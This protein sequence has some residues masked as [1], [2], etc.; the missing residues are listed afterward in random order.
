MYKKQMSAAKAPA[1][2]AKNRAYGYKS[3]YA[4]F[5]CHKEL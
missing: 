2:K 3:P 1:F 5:F 4:L